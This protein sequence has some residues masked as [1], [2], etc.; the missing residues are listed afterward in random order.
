MR[1]P[2]VARGA[3]K[4][5]SAPPDNERGTVTFVGPEG[6]VVPGDALRRI[7]RLV[8]EQARSRPDEE[9]I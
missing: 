1:H 6:Y 9:A 8:I 3:P 4:E 5:P 2:D 7:V